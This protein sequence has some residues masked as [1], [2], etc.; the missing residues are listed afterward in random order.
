MRTI[1]TG[2][3][4]FIGSHLADALVAAGHEVLVIDSLITG[5]RENVPEGAR[6]IEADVRTDE[7]AAAIEDFAPE[8]VF[9]EAA[10]MDVRKSVEDPGYDVD[11]NLRGLVRV[12]EAAR[13]G[14]SLTHF[15]FAGSGGAMYGEQDTFPAPEDHAVKPESPYGLA[16][17]VG[18]QYIELFARMYGF[19]WTSLRYA[20]VYGPRQDAHGEAGVVAIFCGR[21]LKG[22]PLTIY[23]DGGQ[24][25]DFVYVGDVVNANLSA[26]ERE[27]SGG[28]NV[29]TGVETDVNELARV[30]IDI[31]GRDDVVVNHA[32]ERKGEQRR[33]VI[34]P[35]KLTDAA[36]LAERADIREGLERT[37]RW[38]A[39][40]AQG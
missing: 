3:A 39:E 40:R 4:G 21:I 8:V 7:G 27:L 9:H 26:L 10:Q 25:R 1:V 12:L 34:D 36:G 15:L 28:F 22:E 11:V 20:N 23:G 17:A 24:T 33:S 2:G 35:Q 18:E 31:S 16:K 14:G 29:G 13:A 38:F 5:K 37:Y 32:E 6:F 30:L 19:R